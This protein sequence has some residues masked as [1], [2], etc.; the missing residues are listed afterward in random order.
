VYVGVP[1]NYVYC[2]FKFNPYCRD[3]DR[4]CEN[5]QRKMLCCYVHR[6]T[7]IMG[8]ALED[9]SHHCSWCHSVWELVTS[10]VKVELLRQLAMMLPPR[11]FTS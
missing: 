6:D 3:I 1:R 2:K 8:K 9:F 7:I 11:L 10:L 5:W 4:N